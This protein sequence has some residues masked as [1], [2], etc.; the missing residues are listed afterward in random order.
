MT[1]S[2]RYS[3]FMSTDAI[4]DAIELLRAR[5]EQT[6]T[7]IGRLQGEI[8]RIDGALQSLGGTA[9]KQAVS[10]KPAPS[11]EKAASMTITG[12]IEATVNSMDRWWS[13]DDLA[14]ELS[15][16]QGFRTDEQLRGTIRTALWNL[17]KRG[18][19]TTNGQGRQKATR[20]LSVTTDTSGSAATE[21]EGHVST[22]EEGES[23]ASSHVPGGDN[24]PP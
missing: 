10:S 17:R 24:A 13:I 20:Y 21:P 19:V 3:S 1:P 5:R 14:H 2:Q 11:E 7:E 18:K 8:A 22:S 12:A 16:M 23:G 6:Q 15:P 4:A 9:P